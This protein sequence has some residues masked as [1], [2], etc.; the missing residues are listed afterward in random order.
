MPI[1]RLNTY[2]CGASP[3]LVGS[4]NHGV[5]AGGDLNFTSPAFVYFSP[6]EYTIVATDDWNQYVYA[7]LV[8]L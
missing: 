7:I 8:V 6:E 2:D 3:G 1:G 4:W 5:A